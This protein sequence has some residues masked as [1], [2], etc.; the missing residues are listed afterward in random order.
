MIIDSMIQNDS[1]YYTEIR[2]QGCSTSSCSIEQARN[3]TLRQVYS[4]I[5]LHSTLKMKGSASFEFQQIRSGS[6][7][8]E[9][10][11]SFWKV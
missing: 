9:Y 1:Y 11:F 6:R 7:I 5:L 8:K 2:L 10:M 3:R 4:H